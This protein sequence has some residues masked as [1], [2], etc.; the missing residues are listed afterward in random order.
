MKRT[1]PHGLI[2]AATTAIACLASL[3]AMAQTDSA[4]A[5]LAQPFV[6]I[7]GLVQTNARADLLLRE[8]LARGAPDSQETRAG[9]RDALIN[10]ALMEQQSRLEGLDKDI[11]MQAKLELVRQ[12]LLSQAWQQKVGNE[13]PASEAEL[14]A[15]YQQQ[16][17][18]MGDKEFLLR[19]LVVADEA[20]AKTLI[21]KLRAGAPLSELAKAHSID[22]STQSKGGLGEWTLPSNFLPAVA[23][24]VANLKKGSFALQAVQLPLGWYVLQLEDVRPFKAPTMDAIKEQLAG[25]LARRA[26]DARLKTLRDK[27]QVL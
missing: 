18:R 15:E 12:T 13:A 27:A 23:S 11:W 2:R 21:E 5:T 6:T 7:N 25:I 4:L 22:A 16:L 26:I 10:L 20:M 3:G 8:Q 14:K 24:A 9:V 17:A 19:H 1:Q